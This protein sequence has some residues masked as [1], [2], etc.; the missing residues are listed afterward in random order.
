VITKNKL[1]L[2][3]SEKKINMTDTFK[4]HPDFKN[5]KLDLIIKDKKPE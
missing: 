1:I 4:K 3:A 2:V 5:Y